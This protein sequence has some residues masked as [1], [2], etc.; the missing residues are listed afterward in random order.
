MGRW[1]VATVALLIAPLVLVAHLV[2]ADTLTGH[3]YR[4]WSDTVRL[5]YV[6]G[7]SEGFSTAE[8]LRGDGPDT[9]PNVLACLDPMTGGQKHAIVE[10]FMDANPAR[11]HE[12]LDMLVMIALVTACR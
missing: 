8:V 7:F 6:V 12:P 9:R 2:W 3:Q 10:R 5:T 4:R 11:W 1:F